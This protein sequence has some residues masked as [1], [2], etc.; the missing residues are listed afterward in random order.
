VQGLAQRD[1]DV[2]VT[3]G[4]QPMRALI[5]ARTKSPI[6]FAIFNDPISDGFIQ[7]SNSNPDGMDAV[8]LPTLPIITP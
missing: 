5:D 4:P 7:S 2:I 3:A 8:E 6:V 1:P